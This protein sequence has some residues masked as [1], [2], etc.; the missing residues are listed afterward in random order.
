MES[1]SLSI[2]E[3]HNYTDPTVE[4]LFVT[5]DPLHL[6]HLPGSSLLPRGGGDNET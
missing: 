2:P 4:R 1:L 5:A 6:R 3:Q